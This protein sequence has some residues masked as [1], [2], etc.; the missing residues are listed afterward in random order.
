VPV[1]A[2]LAYEFTRFS[3]NH[4][5]SPL[6]RALARPGLWLQRLTTREPDETQLEVGIAALKQALVIDRPAAP[7]AAAS[8]A[9]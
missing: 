4:S 3:A 9:L 8:P 2:G 1:I 7:V 5:Q 6:V